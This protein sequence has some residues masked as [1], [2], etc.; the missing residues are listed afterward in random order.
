MPRLQ[1]IDRLFAHVEWLKWMTDECMLFVSGL[2]LSLD[3]FLHSFFLGLPRFSFFFFWLKL[4]SRRVVLA[5]YFVFRHVCAE[6]DETLL[7]R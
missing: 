4:L 2:F 6:C 1:V 3:S 5:E 7:C